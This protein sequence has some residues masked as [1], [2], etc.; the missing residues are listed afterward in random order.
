MADDNNTTQQQPERPA[1]GSTESPVANFQ[2]EAR[3]DRGG[4]DRVSDMRTSKGDM[5]SEF[6]SLLITDN[7][8]PGTAGDTRGSGE[9]SSGEKTGSEKSN[10]ENPSAEKPKTEKSSGEEQNDKNPDKEKPGAE[11]PK[12]KGEDTTKDAPPE[13]FVWHAGMASRGMN[14]AFGDGPGNDKSS[15]EGKLDSSKSAAEIANAKPEDREK[16][17]G[18]AIDKFTKD[19]PNA[20]PQSLI[21]DMNKFFK[22]SGSSMQAIQAGDRAQ[23]LDFKAISAKNPTGIVAEHFVGK[24]G[25]KK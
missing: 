8:K 24:A 5:P 21:G 1:H 3:E 14:S 19:N 10:S 9:K 13:E 17:F 22:E 6:G 23:L 4:N 15:A 7:S 12:D 16:A 11:K 20:R 2:A 18:N 25:D